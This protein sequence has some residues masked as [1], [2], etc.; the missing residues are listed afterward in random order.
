MRAFLGAAY[1]LMLLSLGVQAYTIHL[2]SSTIAIQDRVIKRHEEKKDPW[3]C[4]A[5]YGENPTSGWEYKLC[6]RLRE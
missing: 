5:P 4:L 1:V 2:Q 6:Y 3:N